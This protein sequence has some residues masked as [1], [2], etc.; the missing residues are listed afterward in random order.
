MSEIFNAPSADKL[1]ESKSLIF[2]AIPK[3]TLDLFEFIEANP[4]S[5]TNVVK[6]RCY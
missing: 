6:F 3:V 4:H 1:L 5:R 2:E